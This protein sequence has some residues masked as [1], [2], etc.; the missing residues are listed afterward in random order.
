M[1]R[2]PIDTAWFKEKMRQKRI[3]QVELGRLL[4]TNDS[5]VHRITHGIRAM[6]VYEV[7]KLA[8]IFGVSV[9]EIIQRAGAEPLAQALSLPIVGSVNGALEIAISNKHPPVAS[10]PVLEENAVG[11]TCDDGTSPYYGWTFVSVLATD[12]RP[13]AIG[14]LSVVKLDSGK[15]VIRF[16]KH[17]LRAGR[18][19][20]A[21]MCDP[22]L[23]SFDV[24][25]ASPVLFIRPVH[26]G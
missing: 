11:F 14:R 19:E 7:V 26:G 12:I 20:V 17:G 24:S 6:W 23:N 25:A 8:R 16:L 18:F 3:S 2:F 1:G 4:G 10:I 5:A 22:S 15:M 9:Y 21:S 13:S